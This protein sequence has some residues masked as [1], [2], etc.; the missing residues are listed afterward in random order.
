MKKKQI[1]FLIFSSINMRYS[2]WNWWR[3]IIIV[4]KKIYQHFV[5]CRYFVSVHIFF[6][7]ISFV[8]TSKLRFWQIFFAMYLYQ[9]SKLWNWGKLG[10]RL[11][12]E[13]GIYANF[14][15]EIRLLRRQKVGVYSVLKTHRSIK[16]DS[17]LKFQ[18]YIHYKIKI[19]TNA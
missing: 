8:R 14:C 15:T 10:A 11:F 13:K 16:I 19:I 17:Y 9:G 3:Y 7:R 6:V 1:F 12:L 18:N 5:F 2:W 4:K